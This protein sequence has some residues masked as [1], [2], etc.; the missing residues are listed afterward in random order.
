MIFMNESGSQKA[1]VLAHSLNVIGI[2]HQPCLC[3]RPVKGVKAHQ[4][5]NSYK[6]QGYRKH[7]FVF[8][9]RCPKIAMNSQEAV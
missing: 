1:I 6:G 8:I 3:F 9:R 2:H 4:H 7:V 5:R